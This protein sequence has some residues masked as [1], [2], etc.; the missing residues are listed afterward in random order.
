M[1]SSDVFLPL[2]SHFLLSPLPIYLAGWLLCAVSA[3]ASAQPPN[4]K[5]SSIYTCTD[6]QGRRLTSDRPIA[7]CSDRE[8]RELGSSGV[9]RRVIKPSPSVDEREARA[10][11]EREAAL[12]RQRERDVMLRNQALV[13]RYPDRVAHDASRREALALTQVVLNAA[14]RR[15]AELG[16]VK[17]RLD[18]EMEFYRQNPSKAPDKLQRAISDNAQEMQDQRHAIAIQQQ[19]RTRINAYFDE[20][21]KR[22]QFLWE[23]KAAARGSSVASAVQR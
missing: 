16:Q 18:N 7:A 20:E 3:M 2:V 19:E 13:S 11:R 6:A 22:L 15:I 12:E 21:S 9:V 17:K 10:T 8:Q 5:P 14:E 1:A 23:A 4:Y